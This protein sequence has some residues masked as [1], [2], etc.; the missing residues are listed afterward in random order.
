MIE[1]LLSTC[2][3]FSFKK[4]KDLYIYLR[5]RRE[6]ER[7]CIHEHES[8]EEQRERLPSLLSAEPTSGQDPRAHKIMT[9]AEITS[10]R[11]NQLSHPGA[12]QNFAFLMSCVV[13]VVYVKVTEAVKLAKIIF[14]E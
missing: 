6:R 3:T 11:L 10:Q 7:K 2:K 13:Y 9:P 5:H 14:F 4:E 8:G 12:P 1:N